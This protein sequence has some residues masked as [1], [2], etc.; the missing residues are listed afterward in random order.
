MARLSP[1]VVLLLCIIAQPAFA[2]RKEPP[3][4]KE[5]SDKAKNAK[6]D[7]D[8]AGMAEKDG[9]KVTVTP[10]DLSDVKAEKDL[11]DGAVIGQ[12]ETETDAG[13]LPPGKYNL[14]AAK[15][16]GEWHV[17]AEAGG[18]LAGEAKKVKMEKMEKTGKPGKWKVEIGSI[19]IYGCWVLFGGWFCVD[20]S[21][22]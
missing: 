22:F 3:T 17:Y 9:K 20:I 1:V 15:V 11:E 8:G 19:N 13:K 6:F 18:K 12:L 14:F 10:A 21:F 4:G 16:N 5:I 7:K 2:E